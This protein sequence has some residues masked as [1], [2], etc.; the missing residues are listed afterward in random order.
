MYHIVLFGLLLASR[1]VS[2]AEFLGEGQILF[3][4]FI[5]FFILLTDPAPRLFQGTA[6]D[7]KF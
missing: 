6:Q 2:G 4:S 5:P 7:K 3:L 1:L